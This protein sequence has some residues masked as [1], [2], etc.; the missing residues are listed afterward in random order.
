MY[1]STAIVAMRRAHKLELER[2][3]QFQHM[4]ESADIKQLHVEHEWVTVTVLSLCF[5]V[6]YLRLLTESYVELLC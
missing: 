1:V 3:R 5:V 2:S 6:A 4:K